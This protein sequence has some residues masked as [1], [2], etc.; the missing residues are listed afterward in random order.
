MA[1]QP[2]QRPSCT[3]RG[4]IL[5]CYVDGKKRF[6][7]MFVD[8]ERAPTPPTVDA[9]SARGAEVTRASLTARLWDIGC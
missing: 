3:K 9:G 6:R 8:S 1:A 4:H 5:T 2:S 7:A